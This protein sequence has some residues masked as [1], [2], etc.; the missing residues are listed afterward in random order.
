MLD[1]TESKQTPPDEP[2][3]R[4]RTLVAAILVS[5]IAAVG[6]LV[7]IAAM[8]IISEAQQSHPDYPHG[9][10]SGDDPG[11]Y[12]CGL[13]SFILLGA[14]P[15]IMCVGFA[16]VA[17]TRSDMR[18][19]ADVQLIPALLAAVLL[20]LTLVGKAD[21]RRAVYFSDVGWLDHHYQVA[22]WV[23]ILCLH[24]IASSLAFMVAAGQHSAAPPASP[25]P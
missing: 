9:I 2:I 25:T 8:F 23:A 3:L 24:L 19:L 5:Y 15:S 14:A 21:V 12:S 20:T 1:A 22:G 6:W 11:V 18:S 17:R 16:H 13:C 10:G 7:P 4:R